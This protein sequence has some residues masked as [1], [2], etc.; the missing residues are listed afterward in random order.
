MNSLGRKV[1]GICREKLFRYLS[2]ASMNSSS[3]STT[4]PVT[5]DQLRIVALRAAIPVSFCF[6]LFLQFTLLNHLNHNF[7]R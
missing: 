3:A 4:K 6:E 7:N 5:T 2:A 1:D